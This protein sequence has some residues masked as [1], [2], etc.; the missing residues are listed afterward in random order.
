MMMKSFSLLVS[1]LCAF[2]T[3][4]QVQTAA[5]GYRPMAKEGKKW[6]TQIGL[7]MENIYDCLIEGDTLIDG[8]NWKKVYKY[9]GWPEGLDKTYYAAIRDVDKKV[10][11]IAKGSN[12]PRLLYDFGLKVGD[13]VRCGVESSLFACLLDADEEPDTLLGYPFKAYL[14]VERI[15]TIETRGQ[16]FRCFTLRLLDAFKEWMLNADP[17]IWVEGVGSGFGPFSPWLPL[18]TKE[19][20]MYT[21]CEEDE[22]TWFLFPNDINK[23]QNTNAVTSPQAAYHGRNEIHGLDGRS[24]NGLPHRGVYI[25]DGWKRVA[26]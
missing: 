22:Y 3:H 14:K 4:A 20:S 16:G 5:D 11:A 18:P 21:T 8:N 24:L 26:K 2:S 1:L 25:Q 15:D 6:E 13:L 9:L 10:Y 7:I 17:V 19:Y 23:W 12:R